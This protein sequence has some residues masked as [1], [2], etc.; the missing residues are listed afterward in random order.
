MSRVSNF[1]NFDEYVDTLKVVKSHPDFYGFA[2]ERRIKQGEAITQNNMGTNLLAIEE[3]IIKLGYRK[4][5]DKVVF[6]YFLHPGDFCILP[7]Y[8]G[9]VP[10]DLIYEP[11]T[12]VLGWEIDS[13][14]FQMVLS[15]KDP[16]NSILIQHFLGTRRRFFRASIRANLTAKQRIYFNL[17][18]LMDMG[19]HVNSNCIE[20]PDF[21]N[22]VVLADMSNVSKSLV[23]SV[24]QILKTEGILISSEKPW[25]I[26]NVKKFQELMVQEEI[27]IDAVK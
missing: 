23:A 24:L 9:D 14:F 15:E 19:F 3:G 2:R 20:L 6:Q 11:V 17:Q 21:I 13:L 22:Y 26:T 8:V 10:A 4:N 27:P 12:D 18:L 1:P 16:Q 7:E 5:E 25:I